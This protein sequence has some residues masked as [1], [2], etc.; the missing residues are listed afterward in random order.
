MG[1]PDP[2]K[3]SLLQ[4]S[5][6]L[7]LA[8]F[9]GGLG[10][11]R[12]YLRQYWRGSFYLLFCWTLL[13]VII[14]IFDVF[15]FAFMKQ[16]NFDRKYNRGIPSAAQKCASCQKPL[17]TMNK[18]TFG[19]GKLADG[20]EICYRCLVNKEWKQ[21]RN[22]PSS[23]HNTNLQRPRSVAFT[24]EYFLLLKNL[25]V[26]LENILSLLQ[27]DKEI[28]D[29][30]LNAGLEKSQKNQFIKNTVVYDLVKVF[31][32]L[33]KGQLKHHPLETTG[34]AIVAHPLLSNDDEDF[35]AQGFQ[36]SRLAHTQ[37]IYLEFA[38]ELLSLNDIENPMQL[39]IQ[40]KDGDTLISESKSENPLA[41]PPFLKFSQHPLLDDYAT[42]LYRFATIIAKADAKVDPMEEILLKE[43]YRFTHQPLPQIENKA[44][45]MTDTKENETLEE[46]LQEL[47]SLI[48][49]SEVKEEINTLMNFIH[50]QK[51]RE[52]AGLK[53]SPISYH[54]V[55]T[56]NP[57]TGKTT[58]ARIVSKIYKHL[59]IL[60]Q[61]HTVETD[62]A[63]LVA[64]YAG[65]T[66]V[67]VN[68]TV[69]TALNGTLFI[70]EAYA[71][72]G[73]NKDDFGKEAVASLIK[74]ME[75]D[76]DKLVVILAGYTQ[77]MSDFIETNPGFKSRFNRYI[78]FPDYTPAELLE[79]FESLCKKLDYT[80][81]QEAKSR[82]LTLFETAY[83][84]RDRSFGNGRLARNIFEKTIENQ[85]N[86]IARQ[87]VLS[88]E[89]LSTI[90][91]ED[92]EN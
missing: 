32:M 25:S 6:T 38:E 34:L 80:L 44:L 52:Q 40:K 42:L 11:H 12:F 88:P 26:S 28:T 67:K 72:V 23:S 69:D 54:I 66:A 39:S 71:L 22:S 73:E 58:V 14:A 27:N 68:K 61:G 78:S 18:P 84:H 17:S 9:L 7:V 82:A 63:G 3:K 83:A 21:L 48:G 59:G 60:T 55:F 87:S 91:H 5:T 57:G 46:V 13:P 81:T 85:A 36:K 1:S 2:E 15:Y 47:N 89:I 33:V 37:N 4:K 43:I 74:R 41:F 86:R 45:R 30:L 8:L 90:T 35:L 56:G 62:R 53:T 24:E 49:L 64:E 20:Q 51:K 79:I 75:D 76:R 50:I 70:D 65:Q 10:V 92:V 19:Q 77:E 29:H 31:R 16:E